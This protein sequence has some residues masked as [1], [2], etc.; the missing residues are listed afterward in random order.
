[1][2]LEVSEF[3]QYAL[4]VLG[5]CVRILF[6]R[7]WGVWLCWSRILSGVKKMAEHMSQEILTLLCLCRFVIW[8]FKKYTADQQKIS[9][10]YTGLEEKNFH[11]WVL[12]NGYVLFNFLTVYVITLNY[13]LHVFNC[14]SE[15]IDGQD[16]KLAVKNSR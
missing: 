6:K 16:C 4:R 1:M 5:R 9:K 15:V 14:L 12:P 11:L 7:K 2:S 3:F 8:N 13:L 10:L